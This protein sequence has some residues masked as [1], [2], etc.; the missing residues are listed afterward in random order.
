MLSHAD[1]EAL[2]RVG[3][4][5]PMGTL[6][7]LYWIPFLPSKALVADGPVKRIRLLGEDL[8]AFRDTQNQVGLIAN[9]CAHRGAPMMFGRNEECGLRCVYHGWKYDVNGDV[10]DMPTEPPGSRFKERV[11]TTA[12]PC[13]ERNGVI[14]TYMGPEAEALPPLPNLEWNLVPETNVEISL[15]VQEC[16]WL[17]ALEGEID[18]AHAPILHGRVDSKGASSAWFASRDLAPSF[19]CVR[20]NFG[21]SIAA[22]RKL[23]EDTLYWRVNQ[24]VM[25]FYTMVPPQS[26][27][28]ELSGHA[29][30]PMDDTHTI[31]I[32]FTYHPSQPLPEK[33]KR[34]FNDGYN[35]RETGHPSRHAFVE[36][37]PAV[38]YGDYRTKYNAGNAF[39]F[40]H[41]SQVTTWFSGLPGLWVQDSACQTG[42]API[43]DRSK[44]KLSSS[45]AGIAMTRRVLLEAVNS[46]R[47]QGVKPAGVEDPDTFLVRAVSLRL[48]PG[49]NWREASQPYIVARPGS[50]FGYTP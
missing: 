25:P 35:G 12:Y 16:N 30:V 6:F 20:Q 46:L 10:V 19:E 41:E 5:T 15:R 9:A 7:R 27:Y 39:L 4:D 13:R 48:P 14:W 49:D 1:N 28:P 37:N 34:I 44:E 40:D 29:W 24:F 8:V 50:D 18:S 45:D 31:C 43:F 17:Q 21:L 3:A 42:L 23:D 2:V 36:T 32:M 22:K 33:M 11:K 47:D 26:Q 38:P